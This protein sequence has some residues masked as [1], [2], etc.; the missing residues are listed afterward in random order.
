M[1]SGFEKTDLGGLA[2]EQSRP[3]VLDDKQNC[4]H[5]SLGKTISNLPIIKRMQTKTSIYFQSSRLTKSKKNNHIQTRESV[6][7]TGTVRS[8][9]K[10]WYNSSRRQSGKISIYD[11]PSFEQQRL[12]CQQSTFCR[13]TQTNRQRCSYTN[14]YQGKKKIIKHHLGRT[15]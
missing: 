15:G 9:I 12:W 13:K 1:L 11:Q 2:S 7:E 3:Q 4:C 6:E 8:Q 5:L 10:N 14:I